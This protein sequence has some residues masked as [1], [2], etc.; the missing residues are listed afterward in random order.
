MDL[1][2]EGKTKRIWQYKANPNNVL[3]E[4]RDDITAGDGEKHNIIKDKGKYCNTITCNNFKLLD[5][6][7]IPNHFL[8]QFN[9]NSFL[10]AKLKMIHLEVIVRRRVA[11]SY[12]Q[13]TGIAE[14]AYLEQPKIEFNF[15]C[16]ALHDPLVEWSEE[17]KGFVVYD[18]HQPRKKGFLGMLR[19]LLASEGLDK[20][21]FILP[22]S[23]Q[24]FLIKHMAL[25]A[26]HCLEKSWRNLGGEIW[27]MKLEFG[28]DTDEKIMLGDVIDND[29]WRL[30][31][32]GEE[33]S[34]Q[35]YRDLPEVTPEG[36]EI[37]RQKYQKI[38]ELS[39]LLKNY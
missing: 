20:N 6:N 7:G 30:K 28:Y 13:R 11:G 25:G 39:E 22:K 27:D 23:K 3:I 9:D 31:I 32:D 16:D 29:S 38:A 12:T 8:E 24:F 26:F 19:P 36:L 35:V 14:G 10:A 2:T 34:K 5:E 21:N 33:M 4:S 1:I 15:K 17:R 18:A 37:V